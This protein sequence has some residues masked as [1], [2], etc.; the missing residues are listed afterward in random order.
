M[1][2]KDKVKFL[3]RA[4]SYEGY[5]VSEKTADLIV[6]TYEE[7]EEHGKKFRLKDAENIE[8]EIENRYNQ[9]VEIV[10][11][12]PFTFKRNSSPVLKNTA[13]DPLGT[14]LKRK[15]TLSILQMLNTSTRLECR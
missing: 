8:H 1:T 6:T 11:Q 15:S 2:H 3:Q 13:K 4:L 14:W 10:P 12:E 7:I 5:T 9:P